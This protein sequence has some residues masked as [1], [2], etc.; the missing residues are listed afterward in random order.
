MSI[1]PISSVNQ[2]TVSSVVA[3]NQ[4]PNSESQEN[5]VNEAV[6]Y[7]KSTINEVSNVTYTKNAV[8]I[9]DAKKQAGNKYTA[10]SDLIAKF[11]EAQAKKDKQVNDSST[12]D[13]NTLLQQ[14]SSGK[15][16]PAD[17]QQSISEDGYWGVKQ[18]STRAID[19]AISLAGGDKT[20]VEELKKAVIEG[21]KQA[22]KAWGGQLPEIS[23]QT[24]EATL[25][26]LDEWANS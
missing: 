26:G 8:T 22:E 18:T 4:K 11:I 3:S 5:V 10:L 1:N 20:K 15:I 23:K 7:E 24:Q 14:I 12:N 13:L 9:D 16:T 6:V 21:Y 25:K 19:F 2:S 17:A